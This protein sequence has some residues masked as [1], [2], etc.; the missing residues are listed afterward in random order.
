MKEI[1][2]AA[3]SRV[4]LIVYS[5][6]QAV[7]VV[8]DPGHGIVGNLGTGFKAQAILERIATAEFKEVDEDSASVG[9]FICGPKSFT[10]DVRRDVEDQKKSGFDADVHIES[11]EW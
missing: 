1:V 10:V 5:N 11:Y 6:R 8:Y 3:D 7:P 9:V 4:S 2:D